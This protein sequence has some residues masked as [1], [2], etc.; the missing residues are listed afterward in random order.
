MDE[1]DLIRRSQEGDGQA[2][3]VLIER[4]KGK[5]FSQ[6]YFS[7]PRFKARSGFGTW[8]YRITVNSAK[9]LLRKNRPR[10]KDVS[11]EDIGEQRLAA[12]DKSQEEIRSEEE[13]RAII[14]A[15]L[16]RLPEKYRVIL[17]LRDIEGMSYEDI[18]RVLGLS[19]GTVDSRLHRAREKLRQRLTS[20]LFRQG[21]SHGL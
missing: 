19:P 18:S 3:G 6:A 13:Q 15:A 11:I 5:V 1:K 7:L 12:S 17:T 2:F 20:T 8:L 16:E 4:Y 14:L 9:D 10:L 21:G